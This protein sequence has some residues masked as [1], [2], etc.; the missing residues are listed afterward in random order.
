MDTFSIHQVLTVAAWFGLTALLFLIALI[1]RKYEKLSGARTYYQ[2]FAVP[3]LLF[4]GG[5]V[6]Q[7]QRD[8]ITGD[9]LGDLLM[10]AAAMALGALCLHTYR[11]MTSK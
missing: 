11:L 5:M 3:V 9:T 6:R 10:F 4:A 2:L 8:Q 7:A 1:A